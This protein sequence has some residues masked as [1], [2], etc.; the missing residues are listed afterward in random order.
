VKFDREGD[1]PFQ[2]D[3]LLNEGLEFHDN[4]N[5]ACMDTFSLDEGENVIEHGLGFR[6]VGYLVIYKEVSGDI[7]GTRSDEWTNEKLFLVSSVPNQKVRL[8]VV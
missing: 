2:L 6:P 8:L 1:I 3:K 5:C 7:F 4:F